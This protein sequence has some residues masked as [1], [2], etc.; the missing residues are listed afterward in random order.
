MC[1]TDSPGIDRLAT[2]L[3]T[4]LL[5][6]IWSTLVGGV[7]LL[8]ARRLGGSL[9]APLATGD[10]FAV[11]WSFSAMA[12]LLRSWPAEGA[13]SSRLFRSTLGSW[14]PWFLAVLGAAAVSLP[15]SPTAG[16]VL[17]WGMLLAAGATATR[18]GGLAR[19]PSRLPRLFR[20]GSLPIAP[21]RRSPAN[22]DHA[23]FKFPAG[24]PAPSQILVRFERADHDII[25]GRVRA[26][27]PAGRRT[28]STHVAFCPP[29]LES[30][31]VEIHSRAPA[32]SARIEAGQVLPHGARFDVRLSRPSPGESKVSIEFSAKGM[33][34]TARPQQPSEREN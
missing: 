24:R 2:W 4:T 29:F 6:A 22:L 18:F 21:S 13:S 10:L 14:A 8:V 34:P 20:R 12:I 27:V 32:A 5:V 9:D 11:G 15:N 30:P 33:L 31:R 19:L 28:A 23:G 17:L 3:R 1:G 16:L 7:S 25:R 26:I